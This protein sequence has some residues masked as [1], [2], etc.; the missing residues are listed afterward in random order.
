MWQTH[1]GEMQMRAGGTLPVLCPRVRER[2]RARACARACVRAS[3]CARWRARGQRA[4]THAGVRAHGRVGAHRRPDTRASSVRT[5]CEKH[6]GADGDT[7]S[8]AGTL[9]LFVLVGWLARVLIQMRTPETRKHGGADG[10]TE[11]PR[12]KLRGARRPRDAETQRHSDRV[13]RSHAE[14]HRDAETQRHRRKGTDTRKRTD[15]RM[16]AQ[17]QTD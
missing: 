7:R 14:S 1:C 15:S 2:P 4:C 3:V 10:D 8:T 11:T 13:T 12:R 9:L 6:R 16:D 5:T 17:T